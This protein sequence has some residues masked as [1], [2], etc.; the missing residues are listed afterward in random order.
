MS[1]AQQVECPLER[2]FT[3]VESGPV[4]LIAT[5]QAGKNNLMTLSCSVSM[6]F[7]PT[8]GFCLGPWNF[9]YPALA[10]GG[11]C[12]VAIPPASLIETVVDIGNCSGRNID[13]FARFGLTAL[14]A[15]AVD[16]PLVGECLFNLECRVVDTALVASRHFFVLEGIAAWKHPAPDDPRTFHA[17]GNGTFVLDG[18]T[19]DLRDRMVKWQ[20]CI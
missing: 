16:A 13:K 4:L 5:R 12:V 6:G 10:Q 15:R 3:F 7:E 17:I 9:S 14:P 8:L 20:D 11:Q 1:F 18:E 19:I 2:A